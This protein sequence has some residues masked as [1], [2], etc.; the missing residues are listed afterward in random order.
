MKASVESWRKVCLIIQTKKRHSIELP[1]NKI[2]IHTITTFR[3][4]NIRRI[5]IHMFLFRNYKYNATKYNFGR[6]SELRRCY[7]A[8]SLINSKHCMLGSILHPSGERRFLILTL[9]SQA[10]LF[11]WHKYYY[12]PHFEYEDHESH[13]SLVFFPGPHRKQKQTWVWIQ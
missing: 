13:R 12:Y 10:Q 1:L 9:P 6:T 5:T 7:R 8:N 4:K 11:M 2:S 3:L